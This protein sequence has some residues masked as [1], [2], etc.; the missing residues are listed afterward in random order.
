M[1]EVTLSET[2]STDSSKG[3]AIHVASLKDRGRPTPSHHTSW[4]KEPGRRPQVRVLASLA[5]PDI[6]TAGG[7]AG[8][9]RGGRQVA[10]SWHG[11]SRAPFGPSPARLPDPNMG[12]GGRA[13]AGHLLSS[14]QP[15]CRDGRPGEP[16]QQGTAARV[17]DP[18]IRRAPV[19]E[20]LRMGWS[21]GP[22]LWAEPGHSR[23]APCLISWGSRS[24]AA[25][26]HG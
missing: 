6:L 13:G 8:G 9:T 22:V 1:P 18:C 23:E 16:P 26:G 4:A 11:C 3:L 19:P 12:W 7:S 5:L 15:Q 20:T 10:G 21:P 25:E 14:P 24:R 17:T 2:Q